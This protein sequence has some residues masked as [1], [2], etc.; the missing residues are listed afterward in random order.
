MR[1]YFNYRVLGTTTV[2]IFSFKWSFSLSMHLL[3]RLNGIL[4][5]ICM[6]PV[7]LPGVHQKRQ[8]TNWKILA[9]SGTRTHNLEISSLVLYRLR[10]L[11]LTPN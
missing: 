11:W 6:E 9:H 1:T 7:D 5:F 3:P 2:A 4:D 8:N 10:G